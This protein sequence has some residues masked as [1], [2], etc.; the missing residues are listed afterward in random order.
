MSAELDGVRVDASAR[1]LSLAPGRARPTPLAVLIDATP[2]PSR[3]VVASTLTDIARAIDRHF[4]ANLFADLDLVA[5]VL[6][7]TAA[8]R[9]RDAARAQGEAIVRLHALFGVETSIR[10][11]YVH[12]F[13]YG[14]DWARW[15]ARDPD[16]RRG[17][18]PFDPVFLAYSEARARELLELIARRDPKY[19]PLEAGRDRNPFPFRRDPEAERALLSSL[20]ARDE[21]PV[22]AWT[23][24]AR[25]AWDRPYVHLREEEARRL[26]LALG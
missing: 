3:D 5:G 25:A 24:D 11:R 12:D 10:F 16:A 17:V 4:P 6:A 20:A 7:E 1:W 8:R 2:A 22:A 9:G 13:L 26:G 21:I 14:F 19:G 23:A 15:V 18:R